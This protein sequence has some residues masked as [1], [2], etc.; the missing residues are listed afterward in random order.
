MTKRIGLIFGSFNP[1]HRGH[2]QLAKTCIDINKVDEVIFIVAKQDSFDNNYHISFL[3]RFD[4]LLLQLQNEDK[5]YVDKIFVSNIENEVEDTRT[6]SVL[7]KLKEYLNTKDDYDDI[8]FVIICGDDMYNQIGTWYN[9]Q[10]ILNDYKFFIFSRK[11]IKEDL[12]KHISKNV[13]GLAKIPDILNISSLDIR[14][15]IKNKEYVLDCISDKVL[16]YINAN[17]LYL[18]DTM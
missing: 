17:N 15:K 6:Y 5:K 12:H 3:Q 2:I 9:G 10:K 4:M 13:I 16:D 14:K 1:V 11:F 8:E 18:E 7:L